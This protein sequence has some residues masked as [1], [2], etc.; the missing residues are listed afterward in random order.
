MSR[1]ISKYATVFALGRHGDPDAIPA[2]EKLL[3]SGKLFFGLASV[4]KSQ[5]EAIRAQ[6]AGNKPGDS[7]YGGRG[8]PAEA[9]AAAG[10]DNAA[11][12]RELEKLERR[13]DE[14]NERLEKIE[15]QISTAKK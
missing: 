8:A 14:M 12:M 7:P 5:I 3:K 10:P 1:G 13:L 11:V 9:S 6:A 2:L 15:E 4:T